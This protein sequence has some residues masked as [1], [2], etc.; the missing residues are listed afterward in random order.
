MKSPL[1]V[2]PQDVTDLLNESLY[3]VDVPV[4]FYRDDQIA[5]E[6]NA[7]LLGQKGK[8]NKVGVAVIV[9]MPQFD[10]DSVETDGPQLV[11]ILTI[12]CVENPL[13]NFGDLGTQKTAEQIAEK[14]AER[15]Q[16]HFGNYYHSALYPV[17]QGFITPSR[18]NKGH[19]TYNVRFK[20][21]IPLGGV[22]RVD[23]PTMAFEPGGG[24][25]VLVTLACS[26][27]GAAIYYTEDESFPKQVSTGYSG[28]F[29]VQAGTIVR[30]RAYKDGLEGS[31]VEG[32]VA[33]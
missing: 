7:A 32:K 3:F 5:S 4:F 6:I 26:T 1:E 21:R 11:P 8:A 2:L 13:L 33:V 9:N 18:E 30:T 12:E 14:V 10:V 23:M 24:G 19:V 16:H 25:T 27:P 28:P 20:C 31:F 15:L 22:A 29:A 17:E